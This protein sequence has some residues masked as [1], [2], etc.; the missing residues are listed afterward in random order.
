LYVCIYYNNIKGRTTIGK[1][2]FNTGGDLIEKDN[3]EEKC[4]SDIVTSGDPCFF[5]VYNTTI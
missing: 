5:H 2:L 3:I 1:Y 4:N